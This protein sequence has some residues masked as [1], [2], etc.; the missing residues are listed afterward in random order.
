MVGFENVAK[1]ATAELA[2][3][4]WLERAKVGAR[5]DITPIATRATMIF[6]PEEGTWKMVHRHADPITTAQPVGDPGVE[7]PL[8]NFG[9]H[10]FPEFGE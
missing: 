4:V 1:Y 2:C 8:A 10:L 7:L 6:R 3:V 5:E 9:E